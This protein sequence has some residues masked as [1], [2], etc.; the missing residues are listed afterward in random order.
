MGQL[1]IIAVN[2]ILNVSDIHFAVKQLCYRG[3]GG[4]GGGSK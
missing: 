4:G 3:G 2:S 1:C